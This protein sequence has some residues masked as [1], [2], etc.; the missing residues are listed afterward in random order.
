MLSKIAQD[1]ESFGQD[2]WNIQT[3]DKIVKLEI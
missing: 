3:K 1:F 2:W